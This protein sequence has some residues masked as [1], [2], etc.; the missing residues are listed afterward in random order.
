MQALTEAEQDLLLGQA[1]LLPGSF[2]HVGEDRMTLSRDATIWKC[3][4]PVCPI[5][6]SWGRQ[7][8]P[9]TCPECKEPMESDR[10]LAVLTHYEEE[11]ERHRDDVRRES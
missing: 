5:T 1:L 9:M 3:M 7:S 2:N 4:D 8:E 11:F 6:S 10:E